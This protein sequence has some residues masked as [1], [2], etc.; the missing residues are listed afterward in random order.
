MADATYESQAKVYR[1]QGA[2]TLVVASSGTLTIEAG[3]TFDIDPSATVTIDGTLT[4][5][6]SGVLNV[7]TGGNIT[8]DSSGQLAVPVTAQTSGQT[9]ASF[10]GA[11]F[12]NTT[13]NGLI[14][15]TLDPPDRAGLVKYLIC[16]AANT[17]DCVMIDV[18][19]CTLAGF[20]TQDLIKFSTAGD[21][22]IL[23]STSTSVWAFAAR[24]PTTVTTTS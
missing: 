15:I 4:V 19:P 21:S 9:I 2:R 16:T 10:G 3:G 18:A 11:T 24:T 20:G 7:D 1:T 17:S 22:A 6:T 5:Q 8:I 14:T 12:S 13:A 23:I